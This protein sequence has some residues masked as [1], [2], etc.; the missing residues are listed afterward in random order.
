M[1]TDWVLVARLA[2]ELQQQLRGARVTDA[3]ALPDGRTA[4]ALHLRGETQL[5]VADPFSSPPLVTLERGE[6]G[7]AREPGFLRSLAATLRG[8]TLQSVS[9]RRGDRLLKL[10]F[11]AHS[12]FGVED[13]VELILELIPRFGNIVLVKRDRVVA[14]AKEFSPSDNAR[15]AVQAGFAYE[16]PPLPGGEPALPR[17]VAARGDPGQA[18]AILERAAAVEQPLYVYRRDGMLVQAHVL[19]LR[20]FEDANLT[21]EPSLLPLLQELH[22]NDAGRAQR[23]RA[24]RRRHA[25]LTKLQRRETKLRGE[26]EALDAKRRSVVARDALRSEGDAVFATLHEL[27]EDERAGAKDRAAKLFARYKKLGAALPHVERREAGVRAALEAVE[28]LRWEAERVSDDDLDDLENAVA[29]IDG[30]A[31][32]P[33]TVASPRKRKRARLEFRTP[34]GSRIVVGR[35][36]LENAE[37]TFKLAGPND[38]WFHARGIPGA[39]VLLSRDDRSDPPHADLEAA[40][41]LAA[42]HSKARHS[43]SVPVDYARRKHV[44]KQ[45]D[46]APGLVWYTNAQTIVAAPRDGI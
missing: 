34:S 2:V 13:A 17:L 28:S 35:S 8:M 6:L 25:V 42:F 33:A 38:W 31:T 46:A 29:E 4:V 20:G 19:P 24:G 32:K 21:R 39:H 30:R 37:L 11:V 41:A 36:P 14:A 43:G 5:L 16:P 44:R 3:G 15:R 27:R 1:T 9:A 12:R 22:E 18:A 26:L 40:A 10:T 23:E 45:R 7:V